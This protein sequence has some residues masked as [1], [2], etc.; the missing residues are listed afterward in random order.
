MGADQVKQPQLMT[1]WTCNFRDQGLY[2]LVKRA[3]QSAWGELR[4][5]GGSGVRLC[6]WPVTERNYSGHEPPGLAG[7]RPAGS[8]WTR[9]GEPGGRRRADQRI[10][11]SP[12]SDRAL[13]SAGYIPRAGGAGV[14]P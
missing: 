3:D 9:A 4:P 14:P 2:H 1:T 12:G 7:Y 6:R 10:R 13:L 8:G 11:T 5:N